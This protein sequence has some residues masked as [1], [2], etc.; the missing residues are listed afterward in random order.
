MKKVKFTQKK[1]FQFSKGSTLGSKTLSE[2]VQNSCHSLKQGLQQ[3]LKKILRQAR[4]VER[5]KAKPKLN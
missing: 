2:I 5:N 4:K 3:N 1:G